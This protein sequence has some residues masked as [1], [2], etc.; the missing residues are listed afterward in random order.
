VSHKGFRLVWV[1][2]FLV[3]SA[4]AQHFV[5]NFSNISS[6][7]AFGDKMLFSGD[8]GELWLSDGTAEGTHVL[9]ELFPE[10]QG[11]QPG[12]FVSLKGKLYFT[13]TTLEYGTEVFS[14]DGTPG[15]TTLLKEINTN[16]G[17]QG[18]SEPRALIVY[19][20]A[21]YFLARPAASSPNLYKSD[22]TA[23]N[24]GIFISNMTSF[25]GGKVAGNYLFLQTDRKR[26]VRTDGTNVIDITLPTDSNYQISNITAAGDNLFFITQDGYTSDHNA[27]L[28]VIPK[29]SAS[30]T[31]V[32][33][34]NVPTPRHLETDHYTT[35]GN[36]IFF[37][38]RIVDET[39]LQEASTDQLWVS[40]GTVAGTQQ[41]STEKWESHFTGSER[42]NFM[43]YGDKLY[44]S[45]AS[46]SNHA[47]WVSDGTINGTKVLHAV[48]ADTQPDGEPA[49]VVSNGL[50]FFGGNGQLYRT[51]GTA[52][53]TRPFS[54][55]K[56]YGTHKFCDVNGT[57]FYT[58]T[59]S[60]WESA[61]Y[62]TKPSPDIKV[63]IDLYSQPRS[64]SCYRRKVT[65]QNNG[66]KELTLLDAA[67]S[68]KEFYIEGSLPDML[69][70]GETTSFNLY[71]MPFEL[72]QKNGTLTI[73]SN[74]ED[75]GTYT[76]P[77][78]VNATA[79]MLAGCTGFN[80]ETAVKLLTASAS[81]RK[82]TLS[83]PSLAEQLPAGTVVGSLAV[84]NA[85]GV[86]AYTLASGEGDANNSDFNIVGD[87][88]VTKRPFRYDETSVVSVHV[89]AEGATTVEDRL[90]IEVL[91][92]YAPQDLGY[93]SATIDQLNV[94]Y[95]DLAINSSGDVFATT[96]DGK[97]F[98]SKDNGLTW[99]MQVI[100]DGKPI[101]SI[102]FVGTR[103]YALTGYRT[104]M[105]SDDQ[106]D[107]WYTVSG[108][109]AGQDFTEMP[110]VH[111]PTED[112]GFL[113][114]DYQLSKTTD[115]GRTW[116]LASSD[117]YSD[118]YSLFFWD[119]L[120]GIA[121]RDYGQVVITNDGGVTWRKITIDGTD[122][123]YDYYSVWFVDRQ[124]GFMLYRG[125]LMKSVDGGEHWAPASSLQTE[126]VSSLEFSSNTTG[127][128]RNNSD[129]SGTFYKTIDGGDTW[130]YLT[131][132]PGVGTAA[133]IDPTT[134]RIFGA[135]GSDSWVWNGEGGHKFVYTD[136]AGSSWNTISELKWQHYGFV[137][138]TSETTGTAFGEDGVYRT[139]DKGLHWKKIN[140]LYWATDVHFFDEQTALAVSQG[141][142][143]KT[144]D[145]CKT[146]TSIFGGEPGIGNSF[147]ELFV[148][149]ANLMFLTGTFNY[150]TT[151]G[152][153]TWTQILE[154]DWV[155][156]MYF[157]TA[158]IGYALDGF[159]GINKTINGGK[160]W[161]AL[162]ATEPTDLPERVFG[163]IF[164]FNTLEGI[165]GTEE[166]IFYKTTDGGVTWTRRN[167]D[168]PGTLGQFYA[169]NGKCYVLST[170]GTYS[171][172]DKGET[173]QKETTSTGLDLTYSGEK[174]YFGTSSGAIYTTRLPGAPTLTSTIAGDTQVCKGSTIT[175]S[176]ADNGSPATFLWNA[177]NTTLRPNGSSASVHFPETGD[178]TIDVR[179][180]NACGTSEPVTLKV[181][182]SDMQQP[183]IVGVDSVSAADMNVPY[184]LEGPLP[185]V[186]PTW[187]VTTPS[188]Y[189]PTDDG[190][191]V[192][193][194]KTDGNYGDV[195][196]I[197]TNALTGCRVEDHITVFIYAP[198]SPGGP[199]GPTDPTDPGDVTGV[200]G[201]ASF[202][203]DVYPNP[204]A[205]DITARSNETTP[206][207]VRV[208]D[209]S[210][211]EH[212][213]Q[214]V[215]PNQGVTISLG[216]LE[217][218]IYVVE[219]V[220]ANGTV[221]D[222]RRI[223]K[224]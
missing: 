67:V 79:T 202:M 132:L 47:L 31:L 170:Y 107:T 217:S 15:G 130:T 148:V 223:V 86:Y 9:K 114:A 1:L 75:E 92:S 112:V 20:E 147:T 63:T 91:E 87:K 160:D 214:T 133:I 216:D 60:Q 146:F 218:G 101:L 34:F 110:L 72:G 14:T 194:K 23:A 109:L 139:T 24:T 186:T 204:T 137:R 25:Y 44:F 13:A 123:F 222:V 162:W 71:F 168:I 36:R 22:G 134:G 196:V 211:I 85:Q 188:T 33:E 205:S 127:L 215:A 213:R 2:C 192:N 7:T 19:N 80:D 52:D 167:S 78:Q 12:N 169:F 11:S 50:L 175:Y 96:G 58:L 172:V 152:G 181:T 65:I 207:L 165:K 108:R 187:A 220:D 119:P 51:D 159:G 219:F 97:V 182:V 208:L 135:S 66:N 155:V 93:C 42:A 10:T 84:L 89:K 140:S 143:W 129:Y 74:D 57:L 150:R 125:K 149:N 185:N 26:I 142:L 126:N 161:D 144:T 62:T 203:L 76:T 95:T 46:A 5:R 40:D 138:F 158:S 136:D 64:I 117:F 111:F 210:G 174:F 81:T 183:H 173:W 77:L 88:L 193:W 55:T 59:V 39:S 164:F 37:S 171:T 90:A 70:P 180:Q 120:N 198:S 21:L 121:T 115:G 43:A 49:G 177:P 195:S 179:R 103:G 197:E 200:E 151:N 153:A 209:T 53:G 113:A 17:V 122:T 18:G 128:A 102:W 99:D 105:R 98:R 27:K 206:F 199:G 35:V 141:Q 156:D 68:G 38:I 4:Q 69:K 73:R 106:G 45:G 30:A 29:G 54:Y 83:S 41:L 189:S 32:R 94:T 100:T 221:R 154:N 82:I 157:P 116:K 145:G 118:W 48:Q 61:L 224:Y 28:Y 56:L 190:V 104:L 131:G 16:T 166:G 178:Y 6:V 3:F 184:T 176:V 124:K 191:A 163:G 8:G 212:L 201:N